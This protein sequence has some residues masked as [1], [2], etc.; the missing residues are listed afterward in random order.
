MRSR[1]DR[2]HACR[3]NAWVLLRRL[4]H[5]LAPGRLWRP[6][7]QPPVREREP[8]ANHHHNRAQPDQQHQRLVIEP[9]RDRTIRIGFAK[10]KIDLANAAPHQR[11]L[12]RATAARW[13]AALRWLHGADQL[14]ATAHCEA[15]RRLAVVGTAAL[16]DIVEMQVVAADRYRLPRLELGD[17][18]AA[19]LRLANNAKQRDA[20]AN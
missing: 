5:S 2:R 11:R 18:L 10:R 13:K 14:A 8:P 16:D 20:E 9:H 3:Q 17:A 7:A 1:A 15:R 12:G 6:D 4:Q 19:K